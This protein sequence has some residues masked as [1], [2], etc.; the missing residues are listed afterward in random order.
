VVLGSRTREFGE[1]LHL[2]E[3]Y[4]GQELTF[5][6]EVSSPGRHLLL[7]L[8]RF[9]FKE[10]TRFVRRHR[11]ERGEFCLAAADQELR[12]AWAAELEVLRR[13]GNYHDLLRDRNLGE[14]HPTEASG[15]AYD[16][17]GHCALCILER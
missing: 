16:W 13:V 15:V 6:Q 5:Q 7:R 3:R 8:E 11:D 4:A 12:S 14:V 9:E 10:T 2:V 1:L 17:L